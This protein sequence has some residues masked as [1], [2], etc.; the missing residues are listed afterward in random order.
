[1][2]HQ[3]WT[4]QDISDD[5][6][7]VSP[8]RKDFF[9]YGHL[10]IYDFA[11]PY[12][13]GARVLDV[14][15]GSGYGSAFL[16]SHGAQQVYGVD[17]SAKAVEFCRDHFSAR[18]LEF[19]HMPA[20]SLTGFPPR[21]FDFIFTSNTL[22]HV[23]GVA[24]FLQSAW[25]LL[26]PDGKLLI[27]VPPITNDQLLYLNLMNPYHINLWSPR[28]WQFAI[29]QYF[30]HVTPVLHGVATIGGEPRPE[31][32]APEPA[33]DE[34]VFCFAAGTIEEM[35]QTF[36]LTAIF[37]AERPRPCEDRPQETVSLPFID[38]SFSRPMGYIDPQLRRRLRAYFSSAEN[39]PPSRLRKAGL[40]LKT[41]GPR[42][43]LKESAQFVRWYLRGQS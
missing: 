19:S 26:K 33:L 23:P 7:R 16:A 4:A 21:S 11:A 43:L 27:A 40:I 20:E 31:H 22:E 18:N 15:C 34:K 14:G 28:Q 13:V 35:Y 32:L 3:A 25:S 37:M 38:D 9:Y 24:G 17:V 30:S 36:T 39:K 29:T 8:L 12:C 5:G 42:G 1:M 41:Q 10:S 6:E 2:E